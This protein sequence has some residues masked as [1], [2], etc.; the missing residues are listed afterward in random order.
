MPRLALYYIENHKIE[1]VKTFFGKEKVLL[2]GRKVSE[3]KSMVG[4]EHTF[5]VNKNHFRISRRDPSK[6]DKMNTHEIYKDGA[7]VALI[8]VEQGMALHFL[9][10]IVIVGIGSGY[11]FGV[12]IYQLFFAPVVP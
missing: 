7:P 9:V 11:L 3:K 8:N 1:I 12:F 2:N 6:T 5:M 4:V 10:L